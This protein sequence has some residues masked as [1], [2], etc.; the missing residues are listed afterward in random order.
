MFDR[1]KLSRHAYASKHMNES[2][3]PHDDEDLDVNVCQKTASIC[4]LRSGERNI[5]VIAVAV[6]VLAIVFCV[7]DQDDK[8]YHQC[9]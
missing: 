8:S 5:V 4:L 2:T 3:R 9:G 6:I 1:E 7:D